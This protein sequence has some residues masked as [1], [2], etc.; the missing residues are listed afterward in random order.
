MPRDRLL[1]T[2]A[3]VVLIDHRGAPVPHKEYKVPPDEALLAA[4]AALVTARRVNDQASALAKQGRLAV[5]PSSHGQEACQVAAVQALSPQDW[6]F[7]TYRD[8][9]AVLLRGVD[10]VQGLS[11]LRGEWHCGY[12]PYEHR[13]APQ[14][15]P[16]ATQLPHAVGVAYAARA[17][18][19]AT[20]VLA[21]CGDGATSEG[22]F[23]EGLNLAAVLRAPVI[24]LVQNNRYAISVPLARQTAAPSLAHKAIGYGMPGT[25]VDGN[26]V[27]ALLAVL[28]AA[29]ERARTGG[30]P[31]LVE[32]HTYRVAPH[33][34]ADD[35]SRYR[36]QDE[37]TQWHD[38]DPITRLTTYL[39]DHGVLTEELSGAATARAEE[40]AAAM[41]SG[42]GA[43]VTPD[44]ANLFAHVYST[45]TPQLIEQEEL[46][47]DELSRVI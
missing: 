37:A 15:T 36:A 32:A 12:D 3:P 9:A 46:V 16:L 27:A 8:S 20:V 14:A 39:T 33:T 13:V 26:D 35:P 21:I 38:R 19:E 5:Y 40:L 17:R 25:R 31:E 24:F 1:P 41:R 11:L 47:L 23:H 34:N 4:H 18:G 7:P 29:V 42:L 30:G 28:G 43:D 6:L 44:L 22:D 45:P 2:E 10:P